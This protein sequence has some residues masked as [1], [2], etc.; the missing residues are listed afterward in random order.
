MSIVLVVDDDR[1]QRTLYSRELGEEG[2]EVVTAADGREALEV[3]A[4]R[5]PDVVVLDVQM[6]NMDGIETLGRLLS[7]DRRIPVILHT[8]YSSYKTNF[9]TWSADAYVVKSS[10]LTEL[11]AKIREVLGGAAEGRA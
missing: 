3:F 6:P 11:K 9:M 1:N 4:L 7:A 2:Y 10:D 8:A 5:S